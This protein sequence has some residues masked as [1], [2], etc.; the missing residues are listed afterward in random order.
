[1]KK[2]LLPTLCLFTV[3]VSGCTPTTS[4]RSFNVTYRVDGTADSVNIAYTNGGG[5]R[6]M[7]NDVKL[8][9]A[10][11]VSMTSGDTVALVIQIKSSG[12]A[13]GVVTG[14]KKEI[15]SCDGSG[16]E[17]MVTCAPGQLP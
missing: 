5:N 7:L 6:N 1:M 3:F 4:T 14:D 16:N 11:T 13:H 8:P 10:K 9:W 12:T 15:S 17:S 2:L